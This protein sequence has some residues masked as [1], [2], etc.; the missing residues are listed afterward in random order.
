VVE[1]NGDYYAIGFINDS[2]NGPADGWIVRLDSQTGDSLASYR[3][4]DPLLEE[5][6][7]SITRAPNCGW[8]LAGYA[9]SDP[10]AA[11]NPW[12]VRLDEQF[13][14]LGELDLEMVDHQQLYAVTRNRD[15][16][17]FAGGFS[18]PVDLLTSNHLAINTLP[19]ETADGLPSP[20][21][22][23]IISD[24]TDAI[25]HWR[26]VTHTVLGCGIRAPIYEVFESSASGP[27]NLLA[28]TTDT[29]YSI[30]GPLQIGPAESFQ[31]RATP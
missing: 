12:L 27:W 26:P 17:Y 10:E 7:A 3:Y 24:G 14:L 11:P 4:G 5:G 23:T 25:L 30:I 18:G 29:L 19:D 8:V 15:G 20:Q 22:L 2:L 31:V 13:N 16:G 6:F 28:T 21:E 1:S 9:A